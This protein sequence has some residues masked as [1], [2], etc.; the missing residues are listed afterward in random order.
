MAYYIPIILIV[1]GLLYPRSKVVLSLFLAYI[2]ALMGLNTYTPD[3]ETYEFTYEHF[4]I[5]NAE[6]YELGFVGLNALGNILGLNYQQFR[7]LYALIY[8]FFVFFASTRLTKYHN[9]L[10]VLFMIWPCLPNVSGLRQSLANM[11]VCGGIPYLFS[12]EKKS[13]IYFLIFNVLGALIHQSVIFYVLILFCRREISSKQKRMLY[14]GVGLLFLIVS[15]TNFIGGL[16]FIVGNEKLDKWLNIN[17]DNAA[18]HLSFT[19]IVVQSCFVVGFTYIV[20][21]MSKY[22]LNFKCKVEEKFIYKINVIRNSSLLLLLTLPGY[23]MS[24][25]YQ[26]YL[27]G[28]LIVFYALYADYISGVYI[29]KKLINNIIAIKFIVMVVMTACYY[30]ISMKSHYVLATLSD[31]L[32]FK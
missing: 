28:L 20:S 17:S 1:L 22:I 2:W 14:C 11:I 13:I 29:P 30:M 9:L 16:S 8:V 23:V 10:L 5:A 12:K 15:S 21:I 26:R 31:N 32:L 18:D 3:W 7:M 27:Y 19:G 4:Y 25:E 24:A 6:G